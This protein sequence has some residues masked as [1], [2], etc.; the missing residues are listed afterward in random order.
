M[1]KKRGGG[2]AEF[3]YRIVHKSGD[4]RWLSQRSSTII[5]PDGSVKIFGISTVITENKRLREQLAHSEKMDAL[6][7]VAGGIAHDL[8]N[9]L[10]GLVSYPDYVLLNMTADNPLRKYIFTIKES[11]LR[12][13]DMIQD[14]LSMARL[15]NLKKKEV[16]LNSIVDDFMNSSDLENILHSHPGLCVETKTDKNLLPVNASY[17]H[18]YRILH[19]LVKNSSEAITE[20]GTIEIKTENFVLKPSKIKRGEL[21]EVYMSVCLSVIRE[22][23]LTLKT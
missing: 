17:Q 10:V 12:A 18:I 23:V 21:S 15:A 2:I 4:I 8:N 1:I 22:K 3:E 11:G 16:I 20:R 7:R 5:I 9:T 19:N 14:L 13:R 6:A